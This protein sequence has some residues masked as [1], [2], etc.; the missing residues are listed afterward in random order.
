VGERLLLKG[1]ESGEGALEQVSECEDV[2]VVVESRQ[3]DR[4]ECAL[5]PA[6]LDPHEDPTPV[7]SLASLTLALTFPPFMSFSFACDLGSL[8]HT[9]SPHS[10]TFRHRSLVA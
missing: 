4:N 9:Q 3:S 2:R 8:T 5:A 7:P 10:S 6:L 1:E